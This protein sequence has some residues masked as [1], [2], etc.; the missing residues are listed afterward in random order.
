MAKNFD[1]YFN[2]FFDDFSDENSPEEIKKEALKIIE[3]LKN[4]DDS[5][6]NIDEEAEKSI[7]DELG[8]PHEIQYYMENNLYFEKK[9]WHCKEGEMVKLTVSDKP[10]KTEENI[11]SLE[12]Q[13][14]EAV[15]NEDYETAAAIRDLIN[16][17]KKKRG[18]PKKNS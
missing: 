4:L 15:K 7:D 17:P 10:I 16:P 9:I 18:R 14:D 13:L 11:K 5:I 1:D 2:E 12:E 3:M 8:E 6:G